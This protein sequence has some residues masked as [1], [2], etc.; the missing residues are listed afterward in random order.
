MRFTGNIIVAFAI[1][2]AAA[3]PYT[4]AQTCGVFCTTN[5]DCAN[6]PLG[7][8]T[9]ESVTLPSVPTGCSGPVTVGVSVSPPFAVVTLAVLTSGGGVLRIS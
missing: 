1:A 9:C 3:V 2:L 6:C 4:S 5:A 8:S 7:L